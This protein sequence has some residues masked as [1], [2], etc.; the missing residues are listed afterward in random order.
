M[1][2]KKSVD[3]KISTLTLIPTLSSKISNGYTNFNVDI[4]FSKNNNLKSL[5]GN[6]KKK[7]SRV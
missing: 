2:G 1:L 3:K 5:L 7:K 6:N 4:V